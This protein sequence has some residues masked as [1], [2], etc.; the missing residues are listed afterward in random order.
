M[1]ASASWTSSGQDGS[2]RVARIA[3]EQRLGPRRDR[4][5]D[6]GRVEREVVLEAGRDVADDAAREHD[7]RHVRDIRRLVEDH[8]VAR[9][10]RR[11]QRKID[12]LRRSDGDQQLGGRVVA[13]AVAALEMVGSARRSSTVPKLDV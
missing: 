7:S 5:F 6:S 2:G 8:L 12:S 3:E 10:A 11:P 4:G 9:I 1:S 13:D